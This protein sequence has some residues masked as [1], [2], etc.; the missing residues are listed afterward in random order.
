ML[1]RLEKKNIMRMNKLFTLISVLISVY[2][3]TSCAATLPRE[4]MLA[5]TWEPQ[6][7]VPYVSNKQRGPVIVSTKNTDTTNLEKQKTENKS[8]SAAVNERQAEQIQHFIGAQM[9]TTMKLNA[10]KTCE[11]QLPEK[12]INANW[13]LKKKGTILVIRN[14][15]SGKKNSL[16]LVF[17][18]DTTAMAIQRSNVGDFIVKYRKQEKK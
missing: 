4:K 17:V 7:I 9:R 13:K 14:S 10:D 3:I 16:E 2:I 6:K 15:E 8:T 11:I 5:G 1:N 18:N 12:L